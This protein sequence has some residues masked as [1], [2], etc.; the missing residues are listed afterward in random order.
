M[1]MKPIPSQLILASASPRRADILSAAGITFQI[2]SAPVEEHRR[3]GETPSDY[4]Q[5]LALEKAAAVPIAPGEVILGA[6]TTVVINGEV[7]EK[8]TGP[9]DA[10]RMLRLLSGNTHQVVTGIALRTTDASICE[11]ETTNVTFVAMTDAEIEAYAASGEPADKAGGYAIQGLAS[12][13][14]RRIDGCYFNVVGLPV[15][16]LW[17]SLKALH[18]KI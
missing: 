11:A 17:R 13:Y 5:R 10:A 9:D 2:R 14:V 8:P 18:F 4:V 1:F 7:L 6:D 12:K 15:S 3:I 16:L